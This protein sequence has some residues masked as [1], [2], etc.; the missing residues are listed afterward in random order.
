MVPEEGLFLSLAS[1]WGEEFMISSE[2]ERKDSR[3]RE[4]PQ[5]GL[6]AMIYSGL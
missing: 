5:Q 1:L 2:T 3:E 4:N 6:N